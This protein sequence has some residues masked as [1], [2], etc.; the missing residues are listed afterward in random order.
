MQH[1]PYEVFDRLVNSVTPTTRRVLLEYLAS[2]FSFSEIVDA[3]PYEV[4][5]SVIRELSTL[6]V[7][8]WNNLLPE[9]DL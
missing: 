4:G 6:D 2:P 8:V 5:S 3:L 9:L 7:I 1:N